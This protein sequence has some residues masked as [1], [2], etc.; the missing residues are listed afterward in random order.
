M[1]FAPDWMPSLISGRRILG[2]V[3]KQKTSGFIS[4]TI[5]SASVNFF[6]GP[7]SAGN[8]SSCAW[9]GSETAT[10]SNRLFFENAWAWWSPRLPVP[11]TTTR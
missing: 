10:T 8:L 11:T 2:G 1:S 3:V 7:T 9:T 5:A 6:T 4:L